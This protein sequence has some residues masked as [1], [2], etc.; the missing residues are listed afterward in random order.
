M[1]QFMDHQHVFEQ[2]WDRVTAALWRKYPHPNC[3]HVLS[4]DVIDRHVDP[5]SGVLHTKRLMTTRTPVPAWAISLLGL[6]DSDCYFVEESTV[7]PR[8]RTMVMRSKNLSL[9]NLLELEET[10]TYSASLDDPNATLFRQETS[11]TAFARGVRT[12]IEKFC[13]NRFMQNSAKGRTV[14]E[15]VCERLQRESIAAAQ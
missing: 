14:L 4:V 2:P 15:E 11:V 8:N 1:P 13:V 12:Q 3:P 6:R 10:C 7:D 9:N 5:V